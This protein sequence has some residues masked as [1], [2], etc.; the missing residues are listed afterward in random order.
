MIANVFFLPFSIFHLSW[1]KTCMVNSHRHF[2]ALFGVKNT[3]SGLMVLKVKWYHPVTCK[4]SHGE[5]LA[6]LVCELARVLIISG[7]SMNIA[8][9][10]TQDLREQGHKSCEAG[11]RANEE[12]VILQMFYCELRQWRWFAEVFFRERFPIYGILFIGINYNPLQILCLPYF[13]HHWLIE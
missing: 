12:L 10:T 6:Q 2:I 8:A 9:F 7:R 1:L 4:G 5:R 3:S 13:S 11:Y